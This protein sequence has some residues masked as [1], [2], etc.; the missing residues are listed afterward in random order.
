MGTIA[1]IF[2]H[3][4]FI[5]EVNIFSVCPERGYGRTAPEIRLHRGCWSQNLGLG[6]LRLAALA[7]FCSAKARGLWPPPAGVGRD[8]QGQPGSGTGGFSC[9]AFHH[10]PRR[11]PVETEAPREEVPPGEGSDTCLSPS[12]SSAGGAEPKVTTAKPRLLLPP[13]MPHKETFPSD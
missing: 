3:L 11:A 4:S 5:L 9:P 7:H 1:I 6:G 2:S 12:S 8:A 13:S 10:N